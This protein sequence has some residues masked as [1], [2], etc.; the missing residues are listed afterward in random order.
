MPIDPIPN[1][2]NYIYNWMVQL[3][4]RET[5]NQLLRPGGLYCV[6]AGHFVDIQDESSHP[7]MQAFLKLFF[8]K[9]QKTEKTVFKFTNTN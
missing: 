1:A 2:S 7:S 3:T 5:F 8:Q 6:Q 9:K 4:S